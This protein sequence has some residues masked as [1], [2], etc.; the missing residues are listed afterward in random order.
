LEADENIS[1]DVD[2]APQI[3]PDQGFVIGL[4]GRELCIRVEVGRERLKEQVH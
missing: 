1:I 4:E 3:E 2:N